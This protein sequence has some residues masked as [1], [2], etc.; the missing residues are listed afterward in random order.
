MPDIA[1]FPPSI[2]NMVAQLPVNVQPP[3]GSVSVSPPLVDVPPGTT[4]QIS[5]R[6]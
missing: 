6:P 2:P 5:P 3:A 1:V 4:G